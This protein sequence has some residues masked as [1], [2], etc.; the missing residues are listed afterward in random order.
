VSKLLN[1]PTYSRK[2][3]KRKNGEKKKTIWI[4][5]LRMGFK[6][7]SETLCIGD[8]RKQTKT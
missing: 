1:L 6:D 2:F 8:E 3:V 7:C 4:F 5:P